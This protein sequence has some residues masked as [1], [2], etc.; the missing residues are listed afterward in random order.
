M[1]HGIIYVSLETKKHIIGNKLSLP[2]TTADSSQG[3][4]ENQSFAALVT[5]AGME[6]FVCAHYFL[7]HFLVLWQRD[8]KKNTGHHFHPL[9][10]S[11]ICCKEAPGRTAMSCIIFPNNLSVYFEIWFILKF[12]QCYYVIFSNT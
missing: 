3:S 11:L 2:S 5:S 8:G 10:C 7:I 4:L 1:A 12:S 9:V 6:M